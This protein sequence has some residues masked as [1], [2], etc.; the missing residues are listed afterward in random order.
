M[1]TPGSSA[2][3]SRPQSVEEQREKRAEAYAA[4]RAYED[5]VH[6]VFLLTDT[7]VTQDRQLEPAAA[8]LS[9][10]SAVTPAREQVRTPELSQAIEQYVRIVLCFDLD[11]NVL[12]SAYRRLPGLAVCSVDYFSPWPS[13][14]LAAVAQAG[15]TS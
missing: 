4:K 3:P 5:R 13:A 10:G 1:P 2:A 14:A 15:R 11:S 12:R 8:L 9:Q 7:F 6:T